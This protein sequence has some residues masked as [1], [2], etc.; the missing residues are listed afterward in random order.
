ML[1][2]QV[3]QNYFLYGDKMPGQRRTVQEEGMKE[4]PLGTCYVGLAPRHSRSSS[5]V[6]SN[7]NVK[8]GY[9][10]SNCMNCCR[11]RN[12]YACWE[13]EGDTKAAFST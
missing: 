6:K 4:G 9:T 5:R 10:F 11:Y 12:R 3:Y 2:D 1:S 8:K 13:P 7:A